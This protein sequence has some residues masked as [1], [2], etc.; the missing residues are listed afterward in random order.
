M[1]FLYKAV[2]QKGSEQNGSIDALNVDVAINSLQRRGFIIKSIHPA[3]EGGGI[4]E[5][6]LSIFNRISNKDVVVI[7]RQIATLFEAQVSA[8]R[9]FRLMANETPNA[10]LGLKL[11]DIA[12]RIQGGEPISTAMSHHDDVFTSFYVNMVK[13]GEESG[14]L[15]QTFMFLADYLDR[16][17]EVT[18]K[19]KNALIYPAFVISTFILIPSLVHNS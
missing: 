3:E 13:A 16:N 5:K 8:L 19:A 10:A 9:V 11:Q 1:L 2:D 17:Y 7:S 12:D 4:L 18:T 6:Q 14:K 15:D